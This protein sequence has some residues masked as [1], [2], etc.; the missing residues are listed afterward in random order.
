MTLPAVSGITKHPHH[1]Q[2]GGVAADDERQ[3]AETFDAMSD[4]HWKLLVEVFGTALRSAQ[5]GRAREECERAS[6]HKADG[7]D[8]SGI[9][10]PG[11]GGHR[12]ICQN[13][14]G[15][16]GSDAPRPEEHLTLKKA[17]IQICE[18]IK[19]RFIHTSKFG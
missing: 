5:H 18:P 15:W 10:L 4:P 16:P 1:L 3:T 13:T 8:H 12:E 9:H 17:P 7:C 2:D 11:C 6:Q 14:A 19:N